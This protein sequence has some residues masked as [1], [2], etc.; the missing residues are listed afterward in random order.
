MPRSSKDHT[1]GLLEPLRTF[2]IASWLLTALSWIVAVLVWRAG[3]DDR[4]GMWNRA[5]DRFTD[6]TH[7]DAVFPYLHHVQFFTGTERF[8]YPAPAAVVY[9]AFLHLTTHRLPVF[10]VCTVLLLLVPSLWFGRRLVVRGMTVTAATLVSGTAFLTSWPLLFLLERANVESLLILLTLAGTVAFWRKW[11]GLA[12]FLWGLAAALKIY[13]VVLLLLFLYRRRLRAFLIGAISA[14]ATLLASFWFVGPTIAIAARGTVHGIVGFVGSY[15][16]HS[17]EWELRHD[18]SF[19]A[20]LKQPLAIHRL[21][22]NSD[23]SHLSAVYFLIAGI[24]LPLLYFTRF[25]RLPALNQYILVMIAMVA[26]PP[27]SYDYTLMHLYPS[28]ALLV[29]LLLSSS[30]SQ[31]KIPVLWP[32]FWCFA[33]IFASENFAFWIAFH[34]NGMIKAAALFYA[35]VLL[36][37]H[38]L[39]EL[40]V[41][42]GVAPAV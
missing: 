22:L 26:L 19:L 20:F 7:Y 41:Q 18:H 23:V 32:L 13:P 3:Y 33:L 10:L 6:L 42:D 8:A 25:R 11:P 39:P 2:V 34:M 17:R 24:S 14:S 40:D 28:F 35:G 36:L 38:P 29:F 30:G 5:D 31:Q 12:A 9:D 27:V 21:H 1:V 16:V 37:R 4:G 15:A